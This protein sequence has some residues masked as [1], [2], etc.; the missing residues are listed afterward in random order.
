VGASNYG[1]TSVAMAE[2]RALQDGLQAALKF[3]Y[4]KLDIEDDNSVVIGALKKETEVPWLIKN[5]MQETQQVE[6]VQITHIY[7]E[8]NMA[9]DWLSKFG[10]S[11]ADAWS[12][13]ESDSLDL[14]AIIQ[15]DRIGCTLVRRGT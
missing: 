1:N 8:A 14:R 4:P 7:R 2:S 3:G 10:H 15:D 12:S 11:I 9:A 5:V 6:Q 13:T